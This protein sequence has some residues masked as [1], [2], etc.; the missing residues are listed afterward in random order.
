MPD[1]VLNRTYTHRSTHGHI[2]NFV[3]GQPTYVPPIL[4]K[5][6]TALGGEPVDGPKVDLIEEADKLPAV[7]TGS[8]R[9]ELIKDVFKK[10]EARNLRGDFTAQG[11]PNPKVLKDLLG[12]EV[13]IRERDEIWELLRK[14]KAEM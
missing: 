2:I 12:F 5:E 3:K 9:A 1:Y 7:P 8:D 10:L 14:E 4:E 11:R 6:I 13:A